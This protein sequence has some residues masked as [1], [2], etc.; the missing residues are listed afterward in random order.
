MQRELLVWLER[1][2]LIVVAI[3]SLGTLLALVGIRPRDP[4]WAH[5]LAVVG[6]ILLC[7]Q[8]VILDAIV[9]GMAFRV[10]GLL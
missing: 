5:T 10:P 2:I 7:L 1:I 4:A 9:G 6:S 3:S 8:T